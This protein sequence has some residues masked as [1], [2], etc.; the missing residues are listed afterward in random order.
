MI[1]RRR[2]VS[3]IAKTILPSFFVCYIAGLLCLTLFNSLLGDMYYFLL[4]HMPSESSHHW[5]HF[6]YNFVPAF[7]RYFSSEN[8]GNIIMFLPFGVLYPLYQK[9]STCLRT[10]LAGICV[11]LGIELLQPIFGQSFDVNDIILN[12]IGIVVSA[13]FFLVVKRLI[14]ILSRR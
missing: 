1:Y 3:S 7:H 6:A 11:L 2:T 14:F 12:G 5:F 10:I 4:Y 8:M 9:N 13:V